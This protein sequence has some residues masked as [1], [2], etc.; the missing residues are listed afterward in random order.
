MRRPAATA[1]ALLVAT[2]LGLL[3]ALSAT[4]A[5]RAHQ[6][7]G[8]SLTPPP[9]PFSGTPVIRTP[10]PPS[11][12]RKPLFNNLTKKQRQQ[13][14]QI[15]KTDK[16][17]KKLIGTKKY[18]FSSVWP[19]ATSSGQLLGGVVT[20]KLKKPRVIAGTWL[21]LAYDCTEKKSPPYGRVPYWAAYANVVQITL[22]IDLKRKKVAGIRP[23]GYLIGQAK[24]PPQ[25]QN[26][27]PSTC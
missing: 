12:T 7:G 27:S 3:T 15:V 1:T 23:L 9:P 16:T 19:W 26:K 22:Y 8:G 5:Q 14:V 13:L 4:S 17:F 10:A 24:Y 18:S 6:S 11:T 2:I 25:Y 20:V 21:D